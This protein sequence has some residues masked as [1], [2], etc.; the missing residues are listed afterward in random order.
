MIIYIDVLIITNFIINYFL[1]KITQ[2]FSSSLYTK[3]RIILSSFIGSFFSLIVLFDLQSYFISLIIKL[4]SLILSVFIAFGFI[5]RYYF[6]KN[7]LSLML[8]NFILYGVIGFIKNNNI[9]ILKNT[10]IYLNINPVL[11]V[12]CIIFIFVVISV[13]NIAFNEKI[14]DED[15]KLNINFEKGEIIL[16]TFYDTG[17]KIKDIIN[18]K[19]IILVKFS[20][21]KDLLSKD[22]SIEIEKFFKTRDTSLIITPI[23]YSTINGDGILPAIK[24]KE[25]KII[26]NKKNKNLKNC[27]I[28]LSK[29]DFSFE[30]DAIIGK[31][32]FNVLK[33]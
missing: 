22:D 8:S 28:A 1:L 25:I 6:I 26:H 12:F 23:F 16:N 10:I 4:I 21:V 33:N 30:K 24:P 9:L 31:E 20:K 29:D 18:N 11:L 5:N 13:F 2:V 32:I 19:S 14:S 17:F 7:I 15:I 3:K 27:L